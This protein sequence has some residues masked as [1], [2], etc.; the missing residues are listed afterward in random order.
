MSRPGIA[1]ALFLAA[2]AF[3]FLGVQASRLFTFLGK[4]ASRLRLHPINFAC[5]CS[6]LCLGFLI[7]ASRSGC[8]LVYRTLLCMLLL[9]LALISRPSLIVGH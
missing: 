9:A 8:S 7:R 1:L 5:M 2:Q 4:Q 6:Y 3:L